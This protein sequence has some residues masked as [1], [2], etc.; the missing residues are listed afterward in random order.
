MNGSGTYTH[1]SDFLSVLLVLTPQALHADL[2]HLTKTNDERVKVP[3]K[4]QQY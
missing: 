3:E 2:S 1:F 4:K